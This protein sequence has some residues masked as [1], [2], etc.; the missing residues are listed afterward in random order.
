MKELAQTRQAE[1][2]CEGKEAG[3]PPQSHWR[4]L[5]HRLKQTG[6]FFEIDGVTVRDTLKHT[7]TDTQRNHC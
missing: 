4:I 1:R 6:C 3:E 7:H 5:L 2:E